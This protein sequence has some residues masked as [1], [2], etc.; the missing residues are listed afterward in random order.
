[1]FSSPRKK[2]VKQSADYFKLSEDQVLCLNLTKLTY[3]KK[4]WDDIMEDGWRVTGTKFQIDVLD[5]E[6]I[7]EDNDDVLHKY[8]T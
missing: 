5:E 2:G 1:M 3:E 7:S 8:D 6:K 4:S